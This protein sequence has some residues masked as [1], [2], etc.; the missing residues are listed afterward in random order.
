MVYDFVVLMWIFFAYP[1]IPL[2]EGRDCVTPIFQM[3]KLSFN[4]CVAFNLV[5]VSRP[6][7][8]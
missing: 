7:W 2:Q 5:K 8:A 4:E 6:R 3:T 1:D